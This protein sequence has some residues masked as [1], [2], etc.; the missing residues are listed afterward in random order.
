MVLG[1]AEVSQEH[2]AA[3]PMA[4]AAVAVA[5]A[6]LAVTALGTMVVLAVQAKTFHRGLV[7][8]Q[9]QRLLLVVLAAEASEVLV[10]RLE[11]VVAK[12][13]TPNRQELQILVLVVLVV[14][15]I[16]LVL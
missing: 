12:Q 4:V 5:Q 16:P 13:E 15:G 10:V 7:K 11:Q 3:I 2:Q 1:L 6:V 14:L 9:I 8:Q